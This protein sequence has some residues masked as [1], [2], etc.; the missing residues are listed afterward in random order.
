MFFSFSNCTMERNLVFI[1]FI[2]RYA[3]WGENKLIFILI[4]DS[5]AVIIC[6][7]KLGVK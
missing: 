5:R 7:R 4:N 3:G 2:L 1:L 6:N